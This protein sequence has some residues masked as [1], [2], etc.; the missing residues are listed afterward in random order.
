MNES[1]SKSIT[2]NFW[3]S[4]HQEEGRRRKDTLPCALSWME[5]QVREKTF[6]SK[7]LSHK[8]SDGTS[9]STQNLFYRAPRRT[10]REHKTCFNLPGL[11]DE[12]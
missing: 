3:Y 10:K 11:K 8:F 9:G 12:V 4:D 6:F 5:R 7:L 2:L 1:S